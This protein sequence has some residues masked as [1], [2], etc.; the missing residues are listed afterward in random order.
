MTHA[1][2][3]ASLFASSDVLAGLTSPTRR[4]GHAAPSHEERKRGSGG[5]SE[6]PPGQGESC[7]ALVPSAVAEGEGEGEDEDKDSDE[8]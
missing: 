4:D 2:P 3:S 8:A 5:I 6:S 7:T 1:L